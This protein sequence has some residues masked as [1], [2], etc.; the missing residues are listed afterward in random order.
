MNENCALP[1]GKGGLRAFVPKPG[2]DERLGGKERLIANG[3]SGG[4]NSHTSEEETLYVI[5]TGFVAE[6]S[7]H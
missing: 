2:Y 5:S 1:Q 4:H 3:K 7:K 6:A